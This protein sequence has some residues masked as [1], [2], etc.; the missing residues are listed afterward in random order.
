MKNLK[1]NALA[2]ITVKIL[3]ILFPLITGP[4]IARTLSK[5]NISLFDSSNT[6]T[7]LFIPFATF[8]IY[9]YGIRAISKV[10]NNI[11]KRNELF[12]EL[13]YLSI[14][15][16]LITSLVYYAYVTNFIDYKNNI[17]I[18]VYLIL[19]LQ[20][21]CQFLY[22]EWVNEA[23]ENYTFILY[24]TI[25][26]RITTFILT[27][28]LIKD[29]D[30]V[31]PYVS[32]MT[33]AE[34]LNMLISFIWIK[35]EVKFV[36]IKI[37]NLLKLIAPLFTM[38]L[39][40]N[41]NMLYVFLDRMFLIKTPISTNISDYVISSNIVMLI[42]GVISGGINV[43]IPRLSYYLG[44]NNFE[45]YENLLNKGSRIFLFFVMPI[46]FGLIILGTEATLIYG[47]EKFL[48][49]GIVTSLFAVRSIIWVLDNILGFQILFIQG[50][51]KQLTFFI[52]IGGI[53]NLILNSLIF[54]NHLFSTEYYILTTIIAEGLVVLL[55]IN[56]IIKKNL[57]KLKPFCRNVIN[58][59]LVASS[60]F[61]V[62]FF[63]NKIIPY[64]YTIDK[65]AI[66]AIITK[67]IAC[68]LTYFTIL[69]ITKDDILNYF[70]NYIKKLLKIS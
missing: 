27:F 38:L 66:I 30:D 35:K 45:E 58:Y 11:T 34:I 41:I 32:I 52:A 25:V 67:I 42:I 39:L 15:S 29:A 57:I 49:A 36:K 47:G 33:L 5:E 1:I 24:K 53:T 6:I 70:L 26:V 14:I 17:H 7:Q 8:G 4:Y 20:I 60:F 19:G 44:E 56:F 28:T 43:N 62:S 37:R 18:Y 10:K 9:S 59:S 23:F 21:I 3:N 68:A 12:S 61:I 13:F 54:Y 50:Y 2:A 51:E 40:A 22:I 63:I 55:Y 31:L 69:Y 65:V 48:S 16:T 46:S 64:G